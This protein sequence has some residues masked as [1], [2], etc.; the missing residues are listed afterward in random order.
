MLGLCLLHMDSQPL[1]ILILLTGLSGQGSTCRTHVPVL[2][3]QKVQHSDAHPT[4]AAVAGVLL[5]PA[6]QPCKKRI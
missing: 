4:A 5:G 2:P 1:T 3:Y 6:A